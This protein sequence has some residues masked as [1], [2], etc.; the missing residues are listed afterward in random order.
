MIEELLAKMRALTQA[1]E[2]RAMTDDEM[3]EYERLEGEL[4]AVRR[5][6]E[7]RSRQR[8]YETP[9]SSPG[10]T[11]RDEQDADEEMRAFEA[12]LRTGQ[13]N[14]D[15]IEA[16]AQSEGTD[17]AGGYLA[18]DSFVQRIVERQKAFGGFAPYATQM[19][20]A[21]GEHTSFPSLDDT[22]HSGAIAA[23]NTE[24]ASGGADLVFGQ[25]AIDAY[26]YVASGASN[27]PLKV[28]VELLQDSRFDLPS[29]LARILGTRLARVQAPDF[30]TGAGSTKP[31]G[32]LISTLTPDVKQ[33]TSG[34]FTYADV[35]S[36]EDA[37]DPAYQQ[38]ARWLMSAGSW[39]KV[40]QMVDDN[41]RPLV[42]PQAAAG[43]GGPIPKELIGYP[44]VIDPA[45]PAAAD[46]T[47]FAVLGDLAEA[48][49][50]RRVGSVSIWV[51]PYASARYVEYEAYE[52]VDGTVQNRNAYVAWAGKDGA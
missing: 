18:P 32:I 48:Y 6:G 1:A 20:T 42:L 44:V 27:A 47:P 22:A 14:H 29:M 26:T 36:L 49:I 34:T 23:E 16:R 3:T 50:I 19:P 9:T 37:L 45:C 17:T 43:I 39:S 15:L 30:V 28:S 2:N 25:V 38:N 21:T 51:N 11:K 7:I 13:P 10:A 12:Y 33:A 52:R 41:G 46:D 31:D 4:T 8:A 5:D 40:R 35:C 24:V